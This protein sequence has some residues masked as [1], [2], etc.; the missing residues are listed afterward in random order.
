M[1]T[2]AHSRL[3]ES[4]DATFEQ[5]VLHATEPVAVVFGATWCGPCRIYDPIAAEVSGE[6]AGRMRFLHVDS[7]ANP[8]LS[9]KYSVRS[10]PTTLYFKGGQLVNQTIGAVPRE[11]LRQQVEAVLA[12]A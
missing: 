5:D 7:D 4:G 3:A 1:S 10:L 12:G 8:Q 6:Y 9:V 11:K 2:T